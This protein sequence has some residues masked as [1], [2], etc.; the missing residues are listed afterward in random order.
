MSIDEIRKK[1]EDRYSTPPLFSFE[2]GSRGDYINDVVQSIWEGFY[3][4]HEM[5]KEELEQVKKEN[6]QMKNEMFVINELLNVKFKSNPTSAFYKERKLLREE[7]EK[8]KKE[9]ESTSLAFEEVKRV[10]ESKITSFRDKIDKLTAALKVAEDAFLGIV[11]TSSRD[12]ASYEASEALAKIHK[13]KEGL[14]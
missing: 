6:E 8:L 1:F 9:I 13:I 3:S 4:A 7:N 2:R 5:I 11:I 14:G 12:K 10:V